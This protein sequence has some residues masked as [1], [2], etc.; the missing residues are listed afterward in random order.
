MNLDQYKS[1]AGLNKKAYEKL[2]EILQKNKNKIRVLEF[3][4]GMSTKFFVDY[5]KQFNNKLEIISFDNDP[6]Y[7][8]KKKKEDD[9]LTLH[10]RNLVECSDINFNKQI[11]D[12]KLEKK[13]F[14]VKTTPPTWRQRNCFYQLEDS[15]LTGTYDIVVIDGPNGNGR[16]ISY[17]YLKKHIKPGT[18]ILID[19]HTSRDNEFDYCFVKYLKHFFNVECIYEYRSDLL[20][21]YEK[22]GCFIFFTVVKHSG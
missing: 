22:G 15:D 9:C 11:N 3:G 16:N 8:Y 17:L 12:K 5:N 2:F 10:I 1:G 19:D 20:G 18:I 6:R 7:C 21:N 13:F 4:S 14:S